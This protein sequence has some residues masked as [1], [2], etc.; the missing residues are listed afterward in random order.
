MN[1]DLPVRTHP[2][3]NDHMVKGLV[4]FQA[5]NL[6]PF[7]H[8][9]NSG[10]ER[11]GLP[12]AERLANRTH[13]TPLEALMESRPHEQLEDLLSGRSMSEQVYR[14]MEFLDPDDQAIL[15]ARSAMDKRTFADLGADFGFSKTNALKR[16]HRALRRLRLWVQ[17]HPELMARF[18]LDDGGFS[19]A[20]RKAAFAVLTG[21]GELSRDEW[22]IT[23]GD[24]ADWD[25]LAWIAGRIARGFNRLYPTNPTALAVAVEAALT[26][27]GG[28]SVL[29]DW[30]CQ[31]VAV[32][33]ASAVQ[34][35]SHLVP[36][37]ATVAHMCAEGTV[38][39]GA[40]S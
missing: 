13:T 23:R 33:L 16:Y 1:P 17:C 11:D 39:E 25:E 35:E 7:T 30:G 40:G 6:M 34:E 31:G 10:G 3:E 38:R 4:D 2:N 14:C 27:Q 5:P 29:R 15:D 24:A 8:S 19:A 37:W 18:G 12:L 26:Q 21:D 28:E 32:H 9:R 20:C 36:V 22:R